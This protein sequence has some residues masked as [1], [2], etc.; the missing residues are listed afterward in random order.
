[1]ITINNT[2]YAT[3]TLTDCIKDETDLIRN[4]TS[5]LK[6]SIKTIAEDTS[7]QISSLKSDFSLMFEKVSSL[8]DQADSTRRLI[9]H[10]V[11]YGKDGIK[12]TIFMVNKENLPLI[13]P[14][15]PGS[16]D[17]YNFEIKLQYI[18]WGIR[19]TEFN[20][21][22]NL[23]STVADNIC[24]I[25]VSKV[26]RLKDNKARVTVIIEKFKGKR[27]KSIKLFYIVD[28]DTKSV[29]YNYKK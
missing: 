25:S 26:K 19:Y 2:A 27:K 4:E 14:P 9:S 16:Y 17:F 7:L 12:A 18:D 23:E 21:P 10:L 29:I 11:E 22:L 13:P 6:N 3:K 20:F 24:N 5:N 15:I 1:M 8:Q 28:L